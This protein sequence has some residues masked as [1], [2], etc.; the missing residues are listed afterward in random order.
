MNYFA[1]ATTERDLIFYDINSHTYT[2]SIII[3]HFPAS[4][5]TI[6]YR[7]NIKNSS[8]SAI[9]CGDSLG[10]LFIFQAK[11]PY[12]PMFHISD[13]IHYMKTDSRRNYSFPRIVNNEYLTVSV[14]SFCNLHNDWIVQVKWIDDLDFF[15]SCALT[16]TRSLYIGDLNKKM[17]KYAVTKKGFAVFDYC[18]AHR[19]IVT[20]S[21]DGVI[22]FWDPFVTERA[23]AILRGH[24]SSVTH[25]VVDNRENHIISIDKGKNIIIWDVQTL[26]TIQRI[27]HT[28]FDLSGQDLTICYLNPTQQRLI[29]GNRKLLSLSHI[30]ESYIHN[31]RTSHIYP[32]T[33]ILYN[34]LFNVIISCDEG[35]TINI[36]NI[37]TGEKIM[38]ILNA[39]V[40]QFD[41]YNEH[42]VE[43]T[44][45]CLDE[46][47]RRL[48][49][50]AHD[51]S[52]ALWNFNNEITTLLHENERLFVAGWSRRIRVFHLGKSVVIRQVDEFR[53]LHND[54]I[55]SMSIMMNILATASYDGDII[56]WTIETGMPFM[57]L[58]S[59]QDTKGAI[60]ANFPKYF[61]R[62]RIKK[63]KRYQLIF[64]H[65]REIN[66]SSATLSTAGTDTAGYVALW[67]IGAYAY[68]Q[69]ASKEKQMKLIEEKNRILT[70]F[71]SNLHSNSTDIR[72]VGSATTLE[73]LRGDVGKRW[74]LLKHT[75]VAW[76][77]LPIFRY[78][79]Q[80]K[81]SEIQKTSNHIQPQSNI[82]HESNDSTLNHVRKLDI[83][84][85]REWIQ[86]RERLQQIIKLDR[87]SENWSNEKR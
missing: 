20:G 52:L 24:N 49:T 77:S 32:I 22:R 25:L 86:R 60:Q 5:T 87:E 53:S 85:T 62:R 61:S 31:E 10:N 75:I 15:I 76:T 72:R 29:I 19:S 23:A 40:T 16:S 57:K 47:K 84:E 1:I 71:S 59:V 78:F 36:W 39:H 79:Y 44:T 8:Q 43:I 6:D 65:A 51:G 37:I 82:H 14:I 35:S 9:F 30:N 3:N 54:D 34:P 41:E 70:Y 81:D 17:E 45:M 28:I 63:F 80:N 50:G 33:K 4:L 26:K 46:S 67:F 21:N 68:K 12:R 73:L 7:M 27:S 13:L 2:G 11:D 58:N 42:A 66:P 48:I 74:K 69:P 38:H 18:K 56:L 64:L 55:L 83:E